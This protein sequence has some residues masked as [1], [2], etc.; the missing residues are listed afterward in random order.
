MINI[1]ASESRWV[2]HSDTGLEYS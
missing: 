2:K 1:A